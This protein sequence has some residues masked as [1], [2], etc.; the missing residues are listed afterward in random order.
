MKGLDSWLPIRVGWETGS[1]FIEWILAPETRFI[2]PFF[3]DTVQQVLRHPF[4]QA[5]R[6]TTDLNELTGHSGLPP[7]GFI[8]HMSRCGSTLISQVLSASDRNLVLSEA[9]PLDSILRAHLRDSEFVCERRAR[10]LRAMLNALSQPC[11]PAE[12]R[13]FVKFDCW[14]ITELP[15]VHE[16]FPDVPWIFLYRDP[17]EVLVSQLQKRSRWSLPGALPP[18]TFGFTAQDLEGIPLDEFAARLLGRLVDVAVD[19]LS[20]YPGGMLINFSELPEACFGRLLHHFDFDP[21]AGELE[22]MRQNASHNS[23]TPGLPYEP[24]CESKQQ[25]ATERVRELAARW[26]EPSYQQLETLR[27]SANHAAPRL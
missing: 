3:E 2:E 11:R 20:R 18:A 26:I 4:H 14:N 5:F 24:D 16:A 13:V 25:A 22:R 1:P 15:I 21:T 6:R 8:F 12:E 7:A 23:K 17:V 10:L 27:R 19:H 9:P